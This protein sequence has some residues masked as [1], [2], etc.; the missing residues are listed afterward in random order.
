[1]RPCALQAVARLGLPPAEARLQSEQKEA[2]E[3]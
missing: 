2:R 1:M 3:C